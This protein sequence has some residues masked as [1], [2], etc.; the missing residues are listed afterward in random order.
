[1]PFRP[2]IVCEHVLLV[3]AVLVVN[4]WRVWPKDAVQDLLPL[5]ALPLC[6]HQEGAHDIR[7]HQVGVPKQLHTSTSVSR[8]YPWQHEPGIR[9]AVYSELHCCQISWPSQQIA[10][11]QTMQPSQCAVLPGEPAE[12]ARPGARRARS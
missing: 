2:C 3:L 5:L 9:Q 4:I 1:M 6:Q 10:A 12:T 8:G 11:G 7:D